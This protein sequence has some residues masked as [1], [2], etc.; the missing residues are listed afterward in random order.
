MANEENL[1]L[2]VYIYLPYY[3]MLI[4]V[5][6]PNYIKNTFSIIINIKCTEFNQPIKS[7]IVFFYF[8][9]V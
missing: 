9:A 7:K 6:V 5:I 1:I 3:K 2:P 8:P 4:V